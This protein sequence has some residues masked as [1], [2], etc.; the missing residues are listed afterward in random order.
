VWWLRED[1]PDPG[2]TGG[3]AVLEAWILQVEGGFWSRHLGCL[4]IVD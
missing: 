4:G 2:M 3:V 1:A